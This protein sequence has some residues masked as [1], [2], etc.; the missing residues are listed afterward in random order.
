MEK[1]IGNFTDNYKNILMKQVLLIAFFLFTIQNSIIGQQLQNPIFQSK[2]DLP[3]L[4]SKTR[5]KLKKIVEYQGKIYLIVIQYNL[6]S[7]FPSIARCVSYYEYDPSSQS[8]KEP[9][10]IADFTNEGYNNTVYDVL[11]YNGVFK[12][13]WDEHEGIYGLQKK[14]KIKLTTFDLKTHN[15]ETKQ[16]MDEV[17]KSDI[18][19]SVSENN[20][21]YALMSEENDNHPKFA[22]KIFDS[23]DNLTFEKNKT[24]LHKDVLKLYRFCLTNKGNLLLAIKYDIGE[25]NV[26]GIMLKVLAANTEKSIELPNSLNMYITNFYIKSSQNGKVKIAYTYGKSKKQNC[27]G[28]IIGNINETNL[29]VENIQKVEV[30]MESISSYPILEKLIPLNNNT[31]Y[32]FCT[33][34]YPPKG[35]RKLKG[36]LIRGVLYKFSD[37][38]KLMGS[39]EMDYEAFND[40]ARGSDD[41]YG[42][43]STVRFTVSEQDA[44]YFLNLKSNLIKYPID[45]EPI[46]L[47]NE[48]KMNDVFR[49][50]TGGYDLGDV[51]YFNNKLYYLSYSKTF[52]TDFGLAIFDL[53]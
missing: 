41:F 40:G 4:N 27:D 44:L 16:L 8:I 49:F 23:N 42:F 10:I 38:N 48:F 51:I 45:A 37:D 28:F 33:A 53:K 6:L 32:V 36:A 29:V 25:R 2:V 20:Q 39:T 13:I 18:F 26:S 12:V 15:A 3:K 22:C 14:S 11:F 47:N 46:L 34:Y 50:N 30:E 21:F 43:R 17:K 24:E 31:S 9:T 52:A 1:K 7:Q 19:V 5:C 35:S